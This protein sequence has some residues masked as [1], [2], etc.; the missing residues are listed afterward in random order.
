M[1]ISYREFKDMVKMAGMLWVFPSS[2]VN[3]IRIAPAIT[4]NDGI[5]AQ[6]LTSGKRALWPIGKCALMRISKNT[7][8][9]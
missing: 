6:I 7:T 5:G 1:K 2:L 3:F 4:V 9:S 8:L